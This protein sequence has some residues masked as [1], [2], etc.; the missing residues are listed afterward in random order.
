MKELPSHCL[1]N[2]GVTGC[3]GT[4]VELHSLRNSI[5][6]VPTIDLARNKKKKKK[7]FLLYMEKYQTIK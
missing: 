7:D 3:G 4:Y 5:I 1:L 2:K 6:L